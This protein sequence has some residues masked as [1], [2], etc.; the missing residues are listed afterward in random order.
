[1]NREMQ[2]VAMISTLRLIAP[3]NCLPSFAMLVIISDLHLTDGSS[4][5]TISPGAFQLLSQRIA[6]LGAGASNRRDG[7]YRPIDRVDL[8]L[9]GD[10]LDVIRSGR[11][12]Q[13]QPR[14]W[15]DV[16][17]PRLAATVAEITRGILTNNAEATGHLR[18]LA[19]HG[20]R[21]PAALSNGRSAT[22]ALQQVPVRIHY[23]VG[24]HDWF[25]HLPGE[26]YDRLRSEVTRALGLA[27]PPQAPFP[28]EAWES[29]ELLQTLRRHRV[30]AR[31][32]DVF[33]PFN[34]EGE[35]DASSLGDV[36]VLELLSR[37]SALVEQ[38]LGEDLPD[39]ALIGLREIDNVRPLL[40][41]PVW[42]EGLLER[43]CPQPALRKQVKR[44][45]D[46]LAAE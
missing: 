38:E 12:L 8:L 6:D 30:F 26:P 32:G 40:L 9:L 36:L 19:E 45:W 11:W 10:V 15:D 34:Y 17:C 28:H 2:R 44:I 33:D 20:I 35:R 31:H 37:F 46:R 27:T 21:V 25:Y 42:I 39:S 22:D 3:P 7:V 13:A 41:I 14:P 4:G 1:D 16:E 5:S 24:N 23:M 18:Q 29:N 43:S